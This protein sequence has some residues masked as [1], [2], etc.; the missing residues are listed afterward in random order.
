MDHPLDRL[1]HNTRRAVQ[2]L[3]CFDDGPRLLGELLR[4]RSRP[5]VRFR[6]PN[7][8]TIDCPN[9][10]GARV[11]VFELFADDAY[12]LDELLAGLPADATILDIGGHIGCFSVA[13]ASRLPHAVVHAYEASPTTASWLA[14]NV[15][16]NGLDGR[17]TAHAEAVGS[18][19]GTIH[20]EDNS[21][22]SSLN[23]VTAETAATATTVAVRCVSLAD[24]FTACGRTPDLVKIDTE[25]AEYD[26]VLGSDPGLWAGVRRIVLEYHDVPGH[27]WD[28]LAG[29]FDRAGFDLVR[30]DAAS[31]RQGTAWLVAR[32]A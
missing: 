26:M 11:P 8:P 18:V 31:P 20:L 30:R 3:R 7:G 13:V 25:G 2:A 1:T 22:G 19:A 28:E 21:A 29:H 17:V 6:V 10:P 23:R 16:A 12:R 24:A 27:D 14:R 9:R 15:A 32:G 4:P 5:E